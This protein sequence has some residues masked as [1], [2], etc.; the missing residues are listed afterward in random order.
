[1]ESC[2]NT[3][4]MLTEICSEAGELQGKFAKAIRKEQIEFY[5]NEF[6]W[7]A[8]PAE[9]ASWVEGLILEMGDILWGIAGLARVLNIPLACVAQKNLDKL[10][11]RKAAGTI[12]GNGD[13][14][15]GKNRT[16]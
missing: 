16:K 2:D 9:Y 4:Y 15:D 11:A 1:M 8:A 12:D 14:I 3:M 5:N 7:N 6:S 13:G 10:S